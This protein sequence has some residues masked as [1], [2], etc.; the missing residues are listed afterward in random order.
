M[1][2]HFDFA[3][4]HEKCHKAELLFSL[5]SNDWNICY[6]LFLLP[7]LE[8]VQRV[9]LS[10]QSNSADPLQLLKDLT[11]LIE[12]ISLKIL[13][14]DHKID[15]IELSIRPYVNYYNNAIIQ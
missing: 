14:F 13:N 5:Y 7:I 9:N 12:T 4:R 1:K 15:V 6:L 10:F 8:L 2:A 11:L 3:R